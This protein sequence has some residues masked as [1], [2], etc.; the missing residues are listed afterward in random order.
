MPGYVGTSI[1]INSNRAHGMPSLSE[2]T[3]EDMVEVREGMKR[4][5]IPV[6]GID[7]EALKVLMQQQMEG[8]RDN[9]PVSAAQAANIILDGVRNEKWRIL[10]GEDARI[11]D[12]LVREFPEEAYEPSFLEKLQAEGFFPPPPEPD[13]SV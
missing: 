9:A 8:F 10:V 6:D 5:G 3:A 13:E 7:D 2:L 12:R 4:V 11:L 1:M